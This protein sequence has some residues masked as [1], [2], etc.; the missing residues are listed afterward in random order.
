MGLMPHQQNKMMK[1]KIATYFGDADGIV[2]FYNEF[3]HRIKASN[4]FPQTENGTT[5]GNYRIIIFYDE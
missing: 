1:G 4:I 3:P 5:T 2:N